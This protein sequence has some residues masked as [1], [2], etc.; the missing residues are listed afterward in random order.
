MA[1]DELEKIMNTKYSMEEITL[2]PSLHLRPVKWSD[3]E[4]VT[5]LIYDVCAADGD[6]DGL[7]RYGKEGIGCCQGSL[8]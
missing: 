4:A 1:L 5:Q 2:D 8:E 6:A 3:L 7:F